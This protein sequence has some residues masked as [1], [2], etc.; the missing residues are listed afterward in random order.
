VGTGLL[1]LLGWVI[2]LVGALFKLIAGFLWLLLKYL[3]P[4]AIVVAAVFI[5]VRLARRQDEPETKAS[6][7][8]EP[9]T[10]APPETPVEPAVPAETL[11]PEPRQDDAGSDD[12]G[13]T[14]S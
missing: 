1:W 4:I 8:V 10:P 2:G 7:P 13:D 14:P 9:A 12:K 11:P 5:L 3:I 6:A